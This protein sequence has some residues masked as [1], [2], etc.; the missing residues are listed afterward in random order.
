MNCI[1]HTYRQQFNFK[2]AM[3]WYKKAI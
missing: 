2:E 3:K 1:A